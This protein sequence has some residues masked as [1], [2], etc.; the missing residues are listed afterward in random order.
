MQKGGEERRHSC[1]S[2]SSSPCVVEGPCVAEF[3]DELGNSGAGHGADKGSHG[4]DRKANG[5]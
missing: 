4:A 5:G 2:S 3:R 1:C